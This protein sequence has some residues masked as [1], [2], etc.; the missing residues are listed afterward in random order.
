M[1]S[2]TLPLIMALAAVLVA[3]SCAT[4]SYVANPAVY[5]DGTVNHP[6][7]VEPGYRSIRISAPLSGGRLSTDES[8]QLAMFVADFLSGGNGALTVS[9]PAGADSSET[10]GLVGEKL[11]A[12]GVPRSRILV[13]TA[14]EAGGHIE[15]GYVAY[16]AH[17]APCGN[18]TQDANDTDENLPMPDFGCSVQH[19]IA[20]MVA[21]PRDLVEPR[22]TGKSDAERRV[23][24][25]KQ[26][27]T[28]AVT[29][30]SKTQE[31]SGAVSSVASGGQ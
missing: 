16:A 23:T 15:I 11:V 20:A 19:N 3:G 24:L 13:G 14:A 7:S 18:W 29:A 21:N 25:T 26:Y 1:Q 28:G 22:G 4:S 31:Q 17:T 10:I 9:V 27:E 5:A 12:M 8:A 2:R 6:I 30:S